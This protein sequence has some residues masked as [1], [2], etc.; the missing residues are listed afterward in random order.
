[1]N[2]GGMRRAALAMGYLERRQESVTHNLANASTP[3]FRGERVFAEL[4]EGAGL[5]PE[6]FARTDNRAGALSKT[7]RPLDLALGA[8]GFLV[9]DTPNG[10]RWS[11]GGSF[12]QD[13]QGRVMDGEGNPL[14]TRDGPLVLPPGQVEFAENGEV[15]VEGTLVA[16]LRVETPRDPEMVE[17]EAGGRF[18]PPAQVD[19]IL[20]E[21]SR[22]LGHTL[23][24]S[25]V[26]PVSAMV[27][28]MEIQRNYVQ[29]QRTVQVMDEVLS[30]LSN[31]IGRVE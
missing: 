21:D 9:V 28:M 25:N 31:Q 29:L 24:E 11:R 8:E 12:T 27:E 23:E 4:L 6:A 14:L 22:V 15:R 17:R 30:T 2:P 1:M 19:R 10:E 5:A 13:T 18:I 26:Q 16:R 7:G 3:G 20:L